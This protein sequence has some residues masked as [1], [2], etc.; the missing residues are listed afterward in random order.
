[1]KTRGPRLPR[2]AA[3][4]CLLLLPAA[5]LSAQAELLGVAV[6][7]GV[8]DDQD[9]LTLLSDVHSAI[10]EP[11]LPANNS[12][13]VYTRWRGSGTHDVEV[14]I[15]NSDT[16]GVVAEQDDQIELSA[17]N[18]V[19]FDTHDFTDT[20]F[21][22]PGEY[23]VDVWLDGRLV[24]QAPLYVNSEDTYP[25][26]PE[27]MLSVPAVDGYLRDSGEADITGV[28]EYFTFKKLPDTDDFSIV[29]AWFSGD[30]KNHAESVRI[31]D[32]KGAVIASSRSLSFAAESGQVA[33]VSCPFQ[34]L[35]FTSEGAYTVE[36]Y[37][38]GALARSYPI[39]AL[40]A[41]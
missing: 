23:S 35:A 11:E 22:E 6:T 9:G 38:D 17:G 31:R 1:V 4:L 19:I 12:F 10:V 26:R 33:V 13:T 27:L 29:T 25:S 37:L 32:P 30:G 15:V 7:G 21:E 36:L 41:K 3:L 5:S 2:A 28:F 8:G 40:L 16:E 39:V 14:Q 34:K 24:E 20:S 18:P